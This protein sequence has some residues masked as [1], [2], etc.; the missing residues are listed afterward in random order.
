MVDVDARN[1]DVFVSDCISMRSCHSLPI[2]IRTSNDLT[3]LKARQR[4][5]TS[6]GRVMIS[7]TRSYLTIQNWSQQ[8]V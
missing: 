7:H 4:L 8:G 5:R 1:S 6:R 3:S 2:T